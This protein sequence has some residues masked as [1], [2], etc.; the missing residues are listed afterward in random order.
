MPN[1]GIHMGMPNPMGMRNPGECRN[2]L[3][4]KK[5]K[6]RTPDW[7]FDFFFFFPDLIIFK[8]KIIENVI[9]IIN[10][11]YINVFFLLRLSLT[12]SGSQ[13]LQEL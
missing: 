13:G 5:T 12:D 7:F 2:D 6:A 3:L 9:I 1:A 8:F 11:F 10:F 4:Q